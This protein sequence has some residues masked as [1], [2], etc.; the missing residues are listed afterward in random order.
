[1][2]L[3]NRLSSAYKSFVY[4]GVDNVPYYRD[5]AGNIVMNKMNHVFINKE[6]IGWS[7]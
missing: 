4:S 3:I 6:M 5:S 7:K 1:M 2:S